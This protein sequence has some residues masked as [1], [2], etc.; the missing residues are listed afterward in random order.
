MRAGVRMRT[1]ASGV[2]LV[3]SMLLTGE[4]QKLRGECQK[5]R[6]WATVGGTG[7]DPPISSIVTSRTGTP[8]RV[9]LCA[10]SQAR[11]GA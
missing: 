11:G 2:A 10:P 9:P 8:R 1:R 7:P 5:L 4:C 6:V 3:G